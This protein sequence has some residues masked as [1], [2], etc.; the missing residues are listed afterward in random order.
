MPQFEYT[1]HLH[2]HSTNSDGSCPIP[3]I[4][5][6]A[7]KAGLDFIGITDH[8]TLA[9][10]EKGHE[11]WQE[12]VLVLVG[13]EF[14]VARTSKNHYIA[15]GINKLIPPD[16]NPQ[17]VID[18]V[19]AQGG[20]GFLAHPV[21]KGNPF[22]L[23]GR[24]FPWERWE[25]SGY[26]GIEIWNFGS[27]WRTAYSSRLGALFWYLADVY[28]AAR[29]P[30]P[31][32]LQIWDR[33]LG[34]RPV[35]GFAGS[36]AHCFKVGKWPFKLKFFP[37]HFLLRTLNTHILLESE[38]KGSLPEDKEKVYG[39][40]KSGRFFT[41]CDYLQPSHGFR[42]TAHNDGEEVTMGG[43]IAYTPQTVLHIVS[44]SPRSIIR[45]IKDGQLVYEVEEEVLVFKVLSAGTFRVEVYRRSRLGKALPWIYSNPIFVYGPF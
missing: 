5:R 2:I 43:R 32:G 16:E 6:A 40:L 12:G 20:F 18:A 41:G 7:R 45:I 30:D 39:A 36:D 24:C 23:E 37:Y 25:V 8:N 31:E 44:P 19:N 11:G 3:E 29:F 22:F 10:M 21:E 15:F 9:G 13:A 35:W 17:Q 26:S 1:G 34:E 28:R 14:S 42:F 27:C 4:A 33:L 38:L